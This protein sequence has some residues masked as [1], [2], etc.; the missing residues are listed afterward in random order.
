[1]SHPK[2]IAQETI[3][4][5]IQSIN[6]TAEQLKHIEKIIKNIFDFRNRMFLNLLLDFTKIKQK[7]GIYFD[8][9]IKEEEYY[10]NMKGQV[11]STN[12]LYSSLQ[13]LSPS[14]SLI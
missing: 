5:I 11:F 13:T 9:P 8:N 2:D 3:L 14:S 4:Q 12:I 10:Y 7:D 6:P 1:M